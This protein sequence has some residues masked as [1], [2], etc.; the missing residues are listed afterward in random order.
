MAKVRRTPPRQP[1]SRLS[2]VV[3]EGGRSKRYVTRDA[4]GRF[5]VESPKNSAKDSDTVKHKS[6]PHPPTK[7]SKG[8]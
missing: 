5:V 4:E 7:K 2:N 3:L 6:E 1:D 8:K